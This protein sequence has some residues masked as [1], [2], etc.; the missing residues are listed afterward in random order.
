MPDEMPPRPAPRAA[1][2]D[3]W[4][5]DMAESSGLRFAYRDG[6][7]ARFYT[8]L[9]MYGGG[10]AMLDYDGDGDLDLFITGGGKLEGPPIRIL[11]RSGAL[12]RN[13]GN[14]RFTDVTRAAGLDAADLY[15]HGPSAADY[16]NDGRPDLYVAGYRGCRL[17]HNEGGGTFRDVTTAAGLACREWNIQGCWAD[18]DRDGRL[19]LFMLNYSEYTPRHTDR[20]I[21]DNDL[22][23]VCGP[24][25][26]E[27][28]PNRLWHHRDD[29]TFEEVTAEAGL[30]PRNR[31]LGIVA[32]DFN[33][34]GW[35]D[36]YVGNDAAENQ[37]YYG[38]P[39]LPFR[40]EGVLSGTALSSAG[41]R[42]GTMGLDAGDFNGD[43]LP[44]LWWVNFAGQDNSLAQK[45]P[46]GDG[47]AAV[48]EMVGMMGVSRPWTAFGTGLVDFDH[49]GWLDIHV[50]NGHVWYES[51]E[52]P[53]LQPAQLFRN[54]EGERFVEISDRGGP[55]FSVPHAGRGAATGDLDD[56]GATDLVVVH[57]NEPVAVLRN[58]LPAA[59]WVRARLR[60]T[61]SNRDGIGAKLSLR[62]GGR[63]LT[64][65]RAG[66]GS[67]CATNDPRILF[68]L[69]GD[70][71]ATITVTWPSGTVE[72][73]G[74][75]TTR[76]THELIE[77]T[78]QTP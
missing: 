21:N 37:L 30:V 72:V 14:W 36:F 55:Y 35:I 76:Q 52:S 18:Y 78:G 2:P 23:D 64:R 39:H 17:Y 57:Q 74:N 10:P 43:G 50:A 8:M 75:L 73:F 42:E 20:C 66:G 15:T 27:G 77:G 45:L 68:P 11:G 4:F 60:G 67:Y 40:E 33:G 65:W 41:S 22:R 16:D 26:Y 70:S 44:D 9:E 62:T 25:L 63:T 13:D 59:A 38:G 49:D 34:D 48:G 19:D 31:G 58:R 54:E 3:D 5:E 1:R 71:P 47:F 6:G 61:R 56:D 32:L 53:Y 69:D 51:R 29:G 7:E 12:F 46:D 28:S 24:T